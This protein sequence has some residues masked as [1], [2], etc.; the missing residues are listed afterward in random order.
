MAKPKSA[1]TETQT[2]IL[3][4]RNKLEKVREAHTAKPSDQLAKAI[5][6]HETELKELRALD[7]RDRFVR[8]VGGR[9]KAARKV[10]RMLATNANPTSYKY[11]S[12]DITKMV[13]V[14]RAEIDTLEKRF[15]TSLTAGAS[16]A[17]SEDDFSF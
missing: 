10:L 3:D 5:T 14:L 6:G 17:K 4:V 8:V 7:N 2:K 12:A 13:G 15:T 11:D 16:A 9:V 1:P